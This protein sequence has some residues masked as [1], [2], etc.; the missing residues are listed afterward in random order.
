MTK[1]EARAE[2]IRLWRSLPPL[3]RHTVDQAVAFAASI[4]GRLEFETL[5][6]RQK[7]VTAW[8]VRDLKQS[9]P[10]VPLMPRER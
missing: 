2:A 4:F 6:D 9:P 7:L 3:E 5:A 8:L 1:D 10:I